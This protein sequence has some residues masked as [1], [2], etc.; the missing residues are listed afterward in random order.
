MPVEDCKNVEIIGW[1][2]QF[3]ISE[4]KDRLINAKKTYKPHEIAYVTQLFTPKW[5]VQYMVDNTLGQYWKEA[6]PNTRI[7][8]DLEFY[9]KPE[10]ENIIPKRKV[11]SPE[12]ISFFDPC[13][14]SGHIL[15]YAFDVFY[16]IYEEEGYNNSDIPELIITRNLFGIDIDDRAAQL[17]GFALMM[18]GSQY[19]RKLLKKGIIPNITAFQDSELHSKFKNAKTLGSLIRITQDEIDKIEID[20]DSIFSEQ[21]QNIK[22]QATL[23]G[24]SYNIVV[25]NPPYLNSTYMDSGLKAYVEKEYRPTK[26]DL[27]ACFLI[28]VKELTIKEGVIGFI[29]P[30]VWM[31]LKSY[32]EL[33]VA[34]IND[35]TIASLVQLEY[36]A[37]GPAVVPIATFV[38]RNQLIMNYKGSYIKLSDFTGSENQAP[39]TIQ[40]IQNPS[41]GWFYHFNQEDYNKITGA[42]IAFWIDSSVIRAFEIGLEFTSIAEFKTG[43]STGDNNRFQRFWYE[44]SFNNIGFNVSS[45]K[46]TIG[47]STKWYPC[48]SGGAFRK[49]FGNNELIVNWENDGMAIRNYFSPNGRLKSRP[50]NIA[51]YFKKSLTWSK[52]TSYRISL[53]YNDDGFTFDAVGLSA[54]IKDENVYY[55]Q[56]LLNS[57]L[58]H[59]ILKLLN[60]SMSIIID[61]LSR[62]PIIF[63]IS[64]ILKSSIEELCKSNIKISKEEWD[65]HEDSWDYRQNELIRIK[66]KE[67]IHDIEEVLYL[68]LQYWKNRFIQLHRNEE[69]INK[70]LNEIYGFNNEIT[71]IINVEDVTI[72]REEIDR[73]ALPKVNKQFVRNS[74]YSNRSEL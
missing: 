61:D 36:N 42:P 70:K 49:W 63:P 33:R 67:S 1:L 50:Q 32:E 13:V 5:I 45:S 26:S 65:S 35:T 12:E 60:Q 72:L 48:K 47:L 17:A 9:I 34:V 11:N 68:Y 56:A 30:Y 74:E 10:N 18:K 31:F 29:C 57:N 64:E 23:I 16:K 59:Y 24:R 40:A 69:D 22:K 7:L 54:F 38:L 39:R 71:P 27:F 19:N 66:N 51:Y 62:L 53:R 37:F 28:K 44:T 21:L 46:D 25:T 43:M 14:G 3:Y 58:A 15:C 52:I 2:Y 4:E 20:N 41:C 8:N 73:S 55:I 6:R